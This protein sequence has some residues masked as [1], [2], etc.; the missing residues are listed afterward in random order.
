[1]PAQDE[2]PSDA[3]HDT[4]ALVAQ[5]AAAEEA[6]KRLARALNDGPS[7]TLSNIVL[8][9]EMIE[10]LLDSDPARAREEARQ[11]REAAVAS[12]AA[13][14]RFMFDTYPSVL[15]DLGLV[16]TLRRYLERRAG[17]DRPPLELRVE[18]EERRLGLPAELAGFRAAQEAL[19]RIDRQAAGPDASLTLSF[20]ADSVEVQVTAQP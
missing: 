4:D 13:I 9:A 16:A 17:P 19:D 2:P 20:G 5:V 7:Q 8:R 15:E 11:L 3:S 14:R 10:R 1:V 6:R 12:L 18:G